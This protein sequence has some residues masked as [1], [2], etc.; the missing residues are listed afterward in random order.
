MPP[1]TNNEEDQNVTW[2][3]SVE[4]VEEPELDDDIDIENYELAT[5]EVTFEESIEAIEGES[6]SM[7]DLLGF[8]DISRKQVHELRSSW[9]ALEETKRATL[10][11]VMLALAGDFPYGDFGRFFQVLLEDSNETVRIH[12]AN[13][14]G[15]SE[16][17]ILIKPLVELAENDP[18]FNV[19]EAALRALA[20]QIVGLDLGIVHDAQDEKRL[21]KLKGWAKDPS[22]PVELRS[23]ALQSYSHNVSDDEI[24]A[25]IESFVD[26][27][28]D[29]LQL[30]A[31]R[32][33][34]EFGP[35]AFTRFLE[36]ELR[37]QDI[38]SREA[39]ALAM[40]QSTDE[41]VVPMLTM[42]AREDQEPAVREAA[43]TG[44]G[45]IGSRAAINALT[46][47][48]ENASDDEI[49]VIDAS[50]QYAAELQELENLEEIG[51]LEF[52]AEGDE[53]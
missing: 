37:S 16:A 5:P 45:N 46:Q 51:M 13:G 43:Y 42:T 27:D 4:P 38:D 10:A 33:M 21:L 30:G 9:N 11:E 48:R 1:E 50:L 53:A 35:G 31:M 34:I 23:A 7:Q 2:F 40:G 41:A 19:R 6:L 22:W 20:P 47:L 49:D 29:T 8:N 28:D 24:G 32:A 25:I 18:S 39:A 44:L 26:S 36:L 15:L 12:A 52:E 17:P 14:A 3:D